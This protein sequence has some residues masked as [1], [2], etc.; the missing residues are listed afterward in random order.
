[1]AYELIRFT[2]ADPHLEKLK[3]LVE[4][5]ESLHLAAKRLL[6]TLLGEERQSLPPDTAQAL[7]QR[8]EA[9]EQTLE[10]ISNTAINPAIDQGVVERL[11]TLEQ[12]LEQISNTAINPAIDQDI[13][14]RLEAL[15]QTLDHLSKPSD[16]PTNL[17]A[18]I[19]QGIVERLETLE[20]TLEQISN[21]AINPAIDQ[22]IVKRLETLEQ[23]LEQISKPSDSPTNLS[24]LIDQGIVERLGALEQTLEQLRSSASV[25]D[26]LVIPEALEK[27]LGTFATLEE[28]QQIYDRAS[29]VGAELLDLKEELRLVNN[30]SHEPPITL[31]VELL[32]EQVDALYEHFNSPTI[33]RTFKAVQEKV[34]P[35]TSA[36]KKRGRPPKGFSS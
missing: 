35:K 18:L 26:S 14:E 1:M 36:P 32:E 2:L 19:D 33:P 13:V 11:E 29:Q 3:G 24:A 5:Q 31:A 27:R 15:E 10:Q 7:E 34:A 25:S 8:L 4:D 20:Q 9:L 23:T 21:T 12:T 30:T 22:G 6:L 17:S 28:F 16:S